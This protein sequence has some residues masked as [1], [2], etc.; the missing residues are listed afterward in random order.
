MNILVS[1]GGG[2]LIPQKWTHRADL[3]IYTISRSGR[4]IHRS[5]SCAKAASVWGFSPAISLREG[6]LE[7]L[8]WAQVEGKI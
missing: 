1:G 7:T 2:P 6:I 3:L 5:Y 8:R 4:R